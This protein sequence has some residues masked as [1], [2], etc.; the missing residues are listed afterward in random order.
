M[1]HTTPLS[2]A[3]WALAGGSGLLAAVAVMTVV[4][5]LGIGLGSGI[6]GGDVATPILG[7]A[8]LGLY[9][10][11]L[12]GIGLAVG[13]LV[14]T[15]IAGEAVAAVV[16]LTFI[17][18]LIA[19]ALKWPDWVHQLALTSHLGQP[20]IGTW[21]WAGMVACAVIA[22]GGVALSSLGIARR[23]VQR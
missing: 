11:A 17:I 1:L 23:D 19:P 22:V 18:E 2:R 5:A 7:T 6:A 13:G 21:D 9:T 10:A 12:V 20:M 16:I 15:S 14:S 4:I 8:V 3:R